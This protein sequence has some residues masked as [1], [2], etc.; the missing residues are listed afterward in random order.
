[1]VAAGLHCGLV[2]VRLYSL[3]G[4]LAAL[5]FGSSNALAAWLLGCLAA[6]WRLAGCQMGEYGKRDAG[7]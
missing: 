4:Y 2:A 1:M 6:D 3:V 7:C 5:I